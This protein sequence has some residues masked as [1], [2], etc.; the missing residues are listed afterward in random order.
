MRRSQLGRRL[1]FV[2]LLLFMPNIARAA[3]DE[4]RAA[5]DPLTRLA[6]D[7]QRGAGLAPCRMQ[8]LCGNAR[9][10]HRLGADT[11]DAYLTDPHKGWISLE[12]KCPSR[13]YPT[14]PIAITSFH[15]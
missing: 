9:R 12:I 4:P 5:A 13:A 10:Q 15:T 14:K 7:A 6:A 11:L 3:P 2:A 8:L 1:C